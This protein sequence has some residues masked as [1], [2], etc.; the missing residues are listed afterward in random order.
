MPVDGGE[1][2]AEM[3][4][5][6]LGQFRNVIGDLAGIV[7]RK[8]RVAGLEKLLQRRMDGR[9]LAVA[10]N[11]CHRKPRPQT[12]T[13]LLRRCSIEVSLHRQRRKVNKPHNTPPRHPEV[14]A[15]RA[16]KDERPPWPSPFEGRATHDHLRVTDY[17]E[18]PSTALVRLRQAQHLFGD[19][20]E[21]Q[22]RADRRDARDHHLAQITL[23]MVFLGVAEA[24]MGHDR[25]LAGLEAGLGSQVFRGIGRGTARQ[26]LV[27][28]PGR[29]QGHHPCRLQLHP[30]FRQRVLDRLILAY[31]PV[32][33]DAPLGVGR[34]AVQRQ[35][36]E[37]DGFGGNQDALGI[38]AMQDVFETAA[39]LAD[40][41]LKR[42]FEIL[43]EQLVGIDRLA[44]HF[45]DLVHGDTRAIEVR[46]EQAEPVGRTF[47]LIER[48]GARQKQHLLR[49][50][51]R[52][53]PDLLAIDDVF[54]ALPLRPGLQL[55]G[56]EPGVRLGDGEAGL[57][58]AVDDRRQHAAALRVVAEHHH[59]VEPEHV[60][61]HRRS[62]RHTGA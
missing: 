14:R 19:E 43:E 53:N 26:A 60:H 29:R 34:R 5:I 10:G 12:K 4:R 1:A 41:I 6:D 20:A 27:V 35:L 17:F 24:A 25:L 31:W 36:A 15:K 56:V 13:A 7:G 28:L 22:L 11:W 45:L 61:M 33:H 52:G 30:V 38:H 16:S 58:P 3:I 46:V 39:L 59:R 18:S 50:L 44:A 23:D 42:N 54:V 57:F 8:A 2:D 9:R 47:H 48:C 21:N 49:D 37:P 40:A 51:G 55:R 62:A 32:E